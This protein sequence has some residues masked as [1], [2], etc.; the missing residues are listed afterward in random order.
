M[1]KTMFLVVGIA[2][3]NSCKHSSSATMNEAA[4]DP[5]AP[6]VC[7]DGRPTTPFSLREMDPMPSAS[8]LPYSSPIGFKFNIP[9]K[10]NVRVD[11]C[12]DEMNGTVEV[13]QVLFIGNFS[14]P[15]LK[16]IVDKS[17]VE[18]IHGDDVHR[19][20][21]SLMRAKGVEN[22]VFGDPSELSLFMP[23]E[24]NQGILVQ[25]FKDGTTV[26]TIAARV[27]E[28]NGAYD[29]N[30]TL[31]LAGTFEQG[32]PFVPVDSGPCK[33]QQFEL[34]RTFTMEK[35]VFKFD[36][37]MFQGG[38]E[39]LGYEISKIEITDESSEL[40][41][42]ERKTFQ[43]EGAE[44]TKVFKYRWNHHNG[45]DSF[46]LTLPHA[47]YTATAAARTGCAS[48]LNGAPVRTIED[49]SKETMY[50]FTYK[51]GKVLEGRFT[52]ENYMLG[53]SQK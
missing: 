21:P 6:M 31:L 11:V 44:M 49:E 5:L 9:S 17:L 14:D 26:F 46:V 41:P 37:C 19:I 32:N 8:V 1:R 42:E 23:T 4:S 39:T 27:T 18:P 24:D 53:C 16:V 7:D 28:Q 35:A 25:S 29:P 52:C 20:P 10:R 15:I 38:G 22:A 2:L 43:F 50:K 36:G 30:S 47:T 13:R 3:C 34:A 51:G 33:E 48:I 45:C 12:V 40:K